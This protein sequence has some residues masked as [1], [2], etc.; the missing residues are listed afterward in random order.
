M[1]F[2]GNKHLEWFGHVKRMDGDR[3]PMRSLE[4][5]LNGKKGRGRDKKTWIEGIMNLMK[6]RGLQDDD[7]EDR[8]E[9]RKR[10]KILDAGS[11]CIHSK[12]VD[13]DDEYFL[14]S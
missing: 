2:V 10:I 8:N 11:S 1:Q 5:A 12:D 13:D 6:D 9:W 7:W 3:L 14:L 4:W